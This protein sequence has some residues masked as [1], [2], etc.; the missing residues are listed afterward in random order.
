MSVIKLLQRT[1]LFAGLQP[2]QIEQIVAL[3]REVVYNAGDIIIQ[4]GEPSDEMY[5]IRDG[6]VEVLVIISVFSLPGLIVAGSSIASLSIA[7]NLSFPCLSGPVLL[8]VWAVFRASWL[9][10]IFMCSR[11]F[12]IIYPL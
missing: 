5:V 12:W 7:E 6:M 3:S 9:G 10:S 11:S 1:E 4:E 2:E 8:L